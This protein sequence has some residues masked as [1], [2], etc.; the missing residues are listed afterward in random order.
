MG[1]LVTILDAKTLYEHR[2]GVNLQCQ[3]KAEP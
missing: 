1:L 2:D 3:G